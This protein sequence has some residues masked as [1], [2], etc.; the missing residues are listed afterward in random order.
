M[1]VST[2]IAGAAALI[3]SSSDGQAGLLPLST[4]VGSNPAGRQR[5]SWGNRTPLRKDASW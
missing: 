2:S 3:S 4:G 5:V 1:G